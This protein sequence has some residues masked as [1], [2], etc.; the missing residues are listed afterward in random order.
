MGSAP[1]ACRQLR[2]EPQRE[3]EQAGRL[4][5]NCQTL[6]ENAEE[7]SQAVDHQTDQIGEVAGSSQT[8]QQSVGRIREAAHEMESMVGAMHDSA[9]HYYL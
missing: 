7:M 4:S 6:T 5:G 2:D 1:A 3:Q 9:A 8:I